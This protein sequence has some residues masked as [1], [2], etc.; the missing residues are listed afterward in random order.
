M[1]K[2][3]IAFLLL[4]ACLGLSACNG[5]NGEG[6]DASDNQEV[7]PVVG[8]P[9]NSEESQVAESSEEAQSSQE[10]VTPVVEEDPYEEAETRE[11]MYRSELT[12]EWLDEMYKDQRPVAIMV[13]NE[14]TALDHYGINS[15]DIVYEMMNSTANG[16]ITRLMCLKKDWQNI[17]QFGS[18]RSA[19]PTNFIL[20]GEWNAILIH[21]GGPF[22]INDYAAKSYSNNLSGGFA[23]FSNGKATEFTEYVTYEDYTNSQKGKTYDGLKDRIAQAKYSTTY[24]DYYTGPHFNFSNKEF[25]LSNEPNVY[26]V[27]EV[28][29]PFYHN[30][31]KLFYNEETRMY[32]YYEYG[33]FHVDPLDDNKVTSFKNVIIQGDPFYQYDENGYMIYYIVGSSTQGWYLTN[34]QAIPINWSKKDETA[35]TIF[36]KVSDGEEIT[37]NTGKTYIAIVPQDSWQ[38][39]EFK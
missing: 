10:V 6:S 23:R 9:I 4:V 38:D 18:I 2:K 32:E 13:D 7:V 29:L 15:A 25:D 14:V 16:R 34:G 17:T 28:H 20:A 39:M 12:N 33:K 19:R 37:L 5:G 31:S 3:K 8:Q 27:K 24:N 22:Y 35:N 36:T 26:D 11:G 21:D 1:K 30:G